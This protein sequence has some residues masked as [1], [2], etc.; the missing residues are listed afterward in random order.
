MVK[1]N[2]CIV[3]AVE[4][5]NRPWS[6]GDQFIL[7]LFWIGNCR[8]PRAAAHKQLARLTTKKARKVFGPLVRFR[9]RRYR[10]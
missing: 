1:K 8:D 3:W 9:A 10:P 2:R 5:S 6:H 4:I 7:R